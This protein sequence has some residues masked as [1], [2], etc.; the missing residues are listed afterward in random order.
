MLNNPCKVIFNI[1]SETSGDSCNEV[2]TK[3]STVFEAFVYKY[4][5]VTI[6]YQTLCINDAK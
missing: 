2:D 4:P 5:I 1:R 6:Y 3:P